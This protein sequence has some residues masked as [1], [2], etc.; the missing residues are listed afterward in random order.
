MPTSGTFTFNVTRQADGRYKAAFDYRGD[1]LPGEYKQVTLYQEL[2][3]LFLTQSA[4]EDAADI[5]GREWL[6]RS[7]PITPESP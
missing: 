2:D 5:A 3:A 7:Y 4:A 6:E 1:L